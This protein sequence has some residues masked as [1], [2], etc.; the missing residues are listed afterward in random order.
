MTCKILKNSRQIFI[1]E[2]KEFEFI[3]EMVSKISKSI[4]TIKFSFEGGGSD[5]CHTLMI[6]QMLMKTDFKMH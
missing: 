2:W 1:S 6:M 4:C 3:C 5:T